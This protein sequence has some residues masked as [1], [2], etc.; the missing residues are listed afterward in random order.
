MPTTVFVMTHKAFD[1]P[2]EKGY[3]AL[4]VGAAMNGNLGI[5]YFGDNSGDNISDLNWLFGEL[6][7]F[8]WIWRNY[9]GRENIGINHYR[10]FF[11]GE[12]GG[13]MTEAEYD[14]ILSEYDVITTN[15]VEGD[16]SH[17]E[18]YKEAHNIHDM[19]AVGNAINKLYPEMYPAFKEVMDL[20]SGYFG[21]LCAMN[22]DLFDAYCEFIFTVF[23]EASADIDVSTY[24]AYHARVYGFLSEPLLQ[25]FIKHHGLKVYE[26]PVMFTAEKTETTELKLA[27]GQ[28]IKQGQID[29]A[30]KMYHDF[31]KI[32][33]DV[34]LPLSD[35][36]G[37]LSIIEKILYIL[38]LERDNGVLGL[39]ER[40]DD[41]ME[42]IR[43]YKDIVMRM[44]NKEISGDV[45]EYMLEVIRRNEQ[46]R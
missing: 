19:D 36:K 37:E 23:T 45:S 21:N 4:Q 20:K 18:A 3:H 10:R 39:R 43:I 34:L 35:I 1:I 41:M 33:P 32:R 42:M 46:V 7:G 13:L 26:N 12:S 27:I 40:T 9:A 44:K 2:G 22:R 16:L 28:L 31:I 30:D 25:V 17:Y 8:Y 29:E 24:D 11:R 14:K 15:A 38:K 6:T 5:Q